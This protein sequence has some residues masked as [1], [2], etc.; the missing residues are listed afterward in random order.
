[1]VVLNRF[2]CT[3]HSLKNYLPEVYEEALGKLSFLNCELFD[4]NDKAY[5]NFIQ[6]VMAGIDNFAP[7]KSKFIKGTLQD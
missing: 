5:E 2:D 4:D 1:M 7:S 3:F 6:K